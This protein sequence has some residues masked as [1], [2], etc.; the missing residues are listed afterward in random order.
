MTKAGL[1]LD[2][3]G[4]LEASLANPGSRRVLRDVVA[5][6][7]RGNTLADA[8]A[9]HPK[10][11]NDLFISLVNVGENTGRLDLAFADLAKYIEVERTTSSVKSATRYPMFALA[12]MAGA[13]AVITVF[14]IPAFSGVF[15]I[16]CSL[17]W[18]TKALIAF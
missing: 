9:Q 4:S 11:F 2:R 3:A 16:G 6:L 18:Q 10:V 7:E 5:K 15:E 17:P 12:A 13:V 8:L 14:V 1:P